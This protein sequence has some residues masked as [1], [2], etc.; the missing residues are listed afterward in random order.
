MGSVV[1]LSGISIA[2]SIRIRV[3][4]AYL[5]KYNKKLDL[6]IERVFYFQRIY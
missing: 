1:G 2:K 6:F 3:K 4:G 5:A